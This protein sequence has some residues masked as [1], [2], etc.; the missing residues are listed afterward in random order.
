MR[1]AV[2]LLQKTLRSV[3]LHLHEFFDRL[4]EVGRW[5]LSFGTHVTAARPRVLRERLAKVGQE[6]LRRYAE[7][8]A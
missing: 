7:S 6:Y 2:F 8:E 5:L 1:T 3:Q 4:E